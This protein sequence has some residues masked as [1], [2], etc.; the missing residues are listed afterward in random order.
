MGDFV[1]RSRRDGTL[2]DAGGLLPSSEG[3]RVLFGLEKARGPVFA[4]LLEPA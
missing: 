2:V 1:E 3:A 4:I